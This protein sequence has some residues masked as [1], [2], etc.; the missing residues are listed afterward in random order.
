MLRAALAYVDAG[1]PIVPGATPYGSSVRRR[2]RIAGPAGPVWVG[3]SCGSLFCA[4]PA[5]HPIDPDWQEHQI[6]S[7]ADVRWWW[8]V[9]SGVLPNIVLVC[10]PAFHVWSM[11]R[12]VGVRV[13]E[14]LLSE[15]MEGAVPVAATPSGWWHLFCSP[16]TAPEELPSLPAGL[17]VVHL[18]NG[19]AVAA[20]PSTRGALGHDMW[21]REP[22]KRSLPPCSVVVAALLHVIAKR[23]GGVRFRHGAVAGRIGGALSADIQAGPVT[24]ILPAEITPPVR[25][26]SASPAPIHAV[27]LRRGRKEDL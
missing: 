4:E 24:C 14:T 2:V 23:A 9:R 17:G 19:H 25:S 5:A 18:G 11:P 20:P 1:W 13:V 27:P 21:L 8:S 12:S 3:C 16:E 22:V 26:P 10:G 15:G 6:T 7:P